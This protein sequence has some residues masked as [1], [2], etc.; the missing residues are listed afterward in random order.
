MREYEWMEQ[1][2]FAYKTNSFLKTLPA[3]PHSYHSPGPEDI[4]GFTWSRNP[5]LSGPYRPPLHLVSNPREGNSSWFG[6]MK[7]LLFYLSKTLCPRP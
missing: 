1:I 4:D 6:E 2:E 3:S 5:L 7:V